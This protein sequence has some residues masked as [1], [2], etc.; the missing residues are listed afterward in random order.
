VLL[1]PFFAHPIFKPPKL[2]DFRAAA[3][4]QII[5]EFL[6]IFFLG[7]GMKVFR[8]GA[9]CKPEVNTAPALLLDFG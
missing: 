6:F 9:S 3:R 7:H 1:A 5:E 2:S 4:S 8:C